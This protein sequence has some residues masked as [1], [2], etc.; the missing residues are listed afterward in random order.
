VRICW[1][2]WGC[3]RREIL[4][5][6]SEMEQLGAVLLMV[7]LW[8]KKQVLP[9]RCGMTIKKEAWQGR[10]GLERV[11]VGG[12]AGLAEGGEGLED[13]GDAGSGGGAEVAGDLGRVLR[14]AGAESFLDG[15]DLIGE[16]RG[17][18]LL[19]A[20]DF[21]F[22][23]GCEADELG[24]DG[25]G[26]GGLVFGA[27]PADEA[28][29]F[30]GAAVGV[31]GDDA[32]EDLL[33]GEGVGPGVGVED[34]AVEPVVDLAEDADEAGLV[35]GGHARRTHLRRVVFEDVF[36]IGQGEPS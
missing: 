29:G 16:G 13:F 10:T 5:R 26:V 12:F 24:G 23:G 21:G 9:M 17:A 32:F 11:A 7:W 14:G 33:V 8:S 2:F 6:G 15:S 34:G 22:G 30:L 20:R 4:G 19:A 28:L 3:R 18:G 36:D 25:D 1:V 35:D 31:E 27:E